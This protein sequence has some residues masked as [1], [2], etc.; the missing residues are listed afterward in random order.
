MCGSD[1]GYA[2]LPQS[3]RSSTDRCEETKRAQE[4]TRLRGSLAVQLLLM[5][6][7]KATVGLEDD[8]RVS[9]S[10]DVILAMASFTSEED[11]WTTEDSLGEASMHL[12]VTLQEGKWP[13]IERVLKE[14]LRPLFTKAKNPAITS[15]GR[16]NLHPVPPS[17]FDASVLDDSTKPW[18]N[19]DIYA[20]R[21]LSWVITQYEVSADHIQPRKLTC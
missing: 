21:V 20:T 18:K 1:R 14:K 2:T 6:S 7:A 15:E 8:T 16:K 5:L 11:P 10:P 17:R 4:E 19:T 13:I 12:S 9:G 3:Y